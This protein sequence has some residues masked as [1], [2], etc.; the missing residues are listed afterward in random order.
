MKRILLV[1]LLVSVVS[2]RTGRLNTIGTIENQTINNTT[3]NTISNTT[4]NTTTVNTTYVYST[5]IRATGKATILVDNPPF[6]FDNAEA[7]DTDWW[8]GVY[9]D[10]GGT[11]DDNM[12]LGTGGTFGTN[13]RLM[14]DPNGVLVTTPVADPN[15]AESGAL[16]Y[17]S[18]DFALAAGDGTNKFW[19]GQKLKFFSMTIWDPDNI[20][21]TEDAIP[22]FPV[23][24]ESF[25]GGITLVDVGI[26]TDASSTY[27]VNFEE[28]TAPDDGSPSTIEAVTTSASLEAEDDGTL[29]DASIA[30]GSIIFVDLDTDDINYLVVWGTYYVN[31]NN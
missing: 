14:V 16:Q 13:I 26:K 10:V 19:I 22:V 9:S 11:S 28:W 3:I 29:S 20:Q 24:A 31:T 30:A 6:F 1:L 25:P 17:D 5:E 4:I 18:D 12:A 23:E 27:A 2:A 7:G 8:M 15:T 21:G